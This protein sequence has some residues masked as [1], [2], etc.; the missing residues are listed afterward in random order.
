M[1]DR[2]SA[3]LTKKI[4]KID[5][6]CPKEVQLNSHVKLLWMSDV[7]NQ[8]SRIDLFFDAGLRQDRNI[9]V[10]LCSSLLLSGTK[11]KT[12][13]DIHNEIDEL[14]AYFDIGLSHEGVMV[15]IFALKSNIFEAFKLIYSAIQEAVFP[16]KEINEVVNEKREKFKIN[17]SRVGFLAQREFQQKIFYKTPYKELTELEDF[18]NFS[19]KNIVDFHENNF[20]KGLSRIAVTGNLMEQE[21]KEIQELCTPNCITEKLM[22]YKDFCNK[23]GIFH[24]DKPNA[25]QSAIRIGKTMFNKNHKDFIEFSIMNTVFGDFF[26]SRL[27]KN[28]RED[29]GYTYGIG[30]ALAETGG[31]GYFI[32]GTEVGIQYKEASLQEIQKEMKIIAE[33]PI[34]EAELSLVKNYLLGQIL[35]L[36]DGPYAMMDLYLSVEAYGLNM[37]FYNTYI[38]RIHS[39]GAEDINKMAKKHLNWDS[40]TVVTSG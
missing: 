12:S 36:A 37:D 31:S 2:N 34:P 6:I 3:P 10:S 15:S 21:I 40:M 9:T 38:N 1:L 29:K 39:I 5:F 11:E 20:K 25:V 22:Y 14:G 28:I 7:P 17:L 23:P 19:R 13:T 35:K 8:T 24:V 30:S 16:E 4:D 18:D 33:K 27:M 32:I 26:G